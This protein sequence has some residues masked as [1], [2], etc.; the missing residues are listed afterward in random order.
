[1]KNEDEILVAIGPM[2]NPKNTY[3]HRDI[4]ASAEISGFEHLSMA[5]G[6]SIFFVF[7]GCSWHAEFRGKSGDF[8]P[9]D[10]IIAD[11]AITEKIKK[12]LGIPVIFKC[13]S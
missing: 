1:M 5:G 9:F 2:R 8:G 3:H 7:D 10:S 4:K 6:G 11:C 13:K 12:Y